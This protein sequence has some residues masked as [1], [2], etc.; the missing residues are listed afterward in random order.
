MLFQNACC[1]T[2][3]SLCLSKCAIISE[4]TICSSNFHGTQVRNKIGRKLPVKDLFPFVNRGHMFASDHCLGISPVSI[5]CWNRL[6]NIGP[7]SDA[8]SL[9]TL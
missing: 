8:S 7:N 9:K 4:Q 2:E 5:D 3:K 1:L 6:T